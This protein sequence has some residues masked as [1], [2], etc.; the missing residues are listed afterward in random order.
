MPPSARRPLRGLPQS[1]FVPPVLR[2]GRRDETV[3]AP[4]PAVRNRR[5]C[6]L[7]FRVSQL[8]VLLCPRW[9]LPAPAFPS[10]RSEGRQVGRSPVANQENCD[11]SSS[12]RRP[13][14][15]LRQI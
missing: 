7:R 9:R 10:N 3:Y 11:S 2:N 1:P 6:Q 13:S 8:P 12:L 4:F 14:R 5:Q 15:E